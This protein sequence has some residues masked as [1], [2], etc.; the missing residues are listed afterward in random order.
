MDFRNQNNEKNLEKI[1]SL[2][3]LVYGGGDEGWR[4][5]MSGY[6]LEMS[7]YRL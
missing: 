1:E 3:E 4:M 5:E 6:R 7:G 2:S